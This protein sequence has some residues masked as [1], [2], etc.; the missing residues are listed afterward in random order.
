MPG[1]Y[2]DAIYVSEIIV[3]SPFFEVRQEQ[4]WAKY[5]VHKI[6]IDGGTVVCM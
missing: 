4:D 3:L 6:C 2:L 1:R 5:G